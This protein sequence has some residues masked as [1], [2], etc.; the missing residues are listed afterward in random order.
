MNHRERESDQERNSYSKILN[1]CTSI[2]SR[3]NWIRAS[4][5]TA[6]WPLFSSINARIKIPDVSFLRQTLHSRSRPA[7]EKSRL[8]AFRTAKTFPQPQIHCT[9]QPPPLTH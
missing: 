3:S 1:R 9:V 5:T 4:T 8:L 6:L 7:P 2:S